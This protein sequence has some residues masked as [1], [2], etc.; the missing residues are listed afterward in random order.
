M[1]S[2][3]ESDAYCSEEEKKNAEKEYERT[4]RRKHFRAYLIGLDEWAMTNSAVFEDCEFGG[5][6]EW[7]V[8]D[9]CCG[10]CSWL[11][12][13]RDASCTFLLLQTNAVWSRWVDVITRARSRTLASHLTLYRWCVC[14]VFDVHIVNIYLEVC[15]VHSIWMNVQNTL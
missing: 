14:P 7:R 6:R 3:A 9:S 15:R 10:C 11:R 5:G 1:S 13:T 12:V 8:A 4:L 2:A